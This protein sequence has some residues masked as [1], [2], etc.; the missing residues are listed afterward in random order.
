MNSDMLKD[1]ISVIIPAYNA[2]EHISRALDSVINQTYNNLDI[3]IIDDGSKDKTGIIADEYAERDSRIRVF[4]VEN[5]GEAKSRNLGLKVAQGDYIAFCD[6]DDCMHHDMV[7]KMYGAI[8]RDNTDVVVCS[9][10][11]V[12][13]SGQIL[14]WN[15]PDLKDRTISNEEAQKIF[16]TSTNIEGFTWNK[17]AKKELYDIYGILYDE[18]VV[19]YC[20]IL[21]SY[22]LLKCSDSVSLIGKKLYD[23]YQMSSSCIHTPNV[24]KLYNYSDTLLKVYNEAMKS[25]LKKQAGI[26]L[27]Y[28]LE[29][30]LYGIY[31]NRRLYQFEDIKKYYSGIY[32]KYLKCSPIRKISWI[33]AYHNENCIKDM[34]KFFIVKLFT[35]RLK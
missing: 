10:N 13:E 21:A 31:S 20:D 12:D 7:E 26:F 22:M 25:G 2:E 24:K 34:I 17:M 27:K 11:Y 35:I 8:K 15:A 29:K 9:F 28:R 19:S 14:K 33:L 32:K 16:L 1:E 4:H 3:I 5:G 6:A 30:Q 18:T 23:Y